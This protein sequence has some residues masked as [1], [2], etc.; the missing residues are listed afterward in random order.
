M[1]IPAE[2]DREADGADFG[3][4]VRGR[5][6]RETVG[7]VVTRLRLYPG[8]RAFADVI[9]AHSND[10][11]KVAGH[12]IGGLKI[13]TIAAEAGMSTRHA[14]RCARQLECAG[15]LGVERRPGDGVTMLP[16]LWHLTVRTW[17]LGA[18]LLREW[19]RRIEDKREAQYLKG[20]AK[21]LTAKIGPKPEPLRRSPTF[22]CEQFDC[23]WRGA[24]GPCPIHGPPAS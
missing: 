16:N 13:A 11:G 20:L 1:T 2:S 22:V 9:A 18:Q 4:P 6:W 24:H 17:S 8:C 12:P 3:T 21:D 19:T 14:H 7:K 23:G 15:V 5:P 10:A